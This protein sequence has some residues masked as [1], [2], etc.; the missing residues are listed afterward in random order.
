MNRLLMNSKVI[1]KFKH[2]QVHMVFSSSMVHT[3]FCLNLLVSACVYPARRGGDPCVYSLTVFSLSTVK[4]K[5]K[6]LEPWTILKKQIDSLFSHFVFAHSDNLHVSSS[7]TFVLSHLPVKLETA[8][9]SCKPHTQ[10]WELLDPAL[11]RPPI[12][13]IF[14]LF[15]PMPAYMSQQVVSVN[16]FWREIV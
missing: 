2:S 3:L 13:F 5:T 9:S 6:V 12:Y 8:N 14:K 11:Q 16:V 1:R 15:Y 7:V 10:I 4:S